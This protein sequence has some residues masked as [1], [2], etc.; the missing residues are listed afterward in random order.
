L[1]RSALPP[2][3]GLQFGRGVNFYPAPSFALVLGHPPNPLFPPRSRANG[4]I[5]RRRNW[6]PCQFHW[7]A[8][9]NFFYFNHFT[10]ISITW[11]ICVAVKTRPT[12]VNQKIRFCNFSFLLSNETIVSSSLVMDFLSLQISTT[13]NSILLFAVAIKSF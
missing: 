9:L 8:A 3:G 5:F 7:R 4:K 10:T 11:I 1:T 6:R 2:A 13:A 12:T